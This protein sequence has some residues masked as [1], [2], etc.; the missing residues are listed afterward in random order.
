MEQKLKVV[1]WWFE[2]KSF[3]AERHRY[4]HEFNCGMLESLIN[5]LLNPHFD[6]WSLLIPH[7]EPIGIITLPIPLRR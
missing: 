6:A 7:I 2:D 4:A 5:E 1:S 3:T